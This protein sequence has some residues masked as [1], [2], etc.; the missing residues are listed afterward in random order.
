MPNSKKIGK[1]EFIQ[2]TSQYI[3]WVEEHNSQLVITHHN[4]P[5]LLLTKIKH[6]SLK[7]LRGSVN[8]KIHGNINEAVLPEYDEW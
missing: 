1:R 8:L 3:K 4:Q 5:G 7:D 6:K 2:N